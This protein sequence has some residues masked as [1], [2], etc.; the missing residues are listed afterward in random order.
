MSVPIRRLPH[1][2]AVVPIAF[3]RARTGAYAREKGLGR[4]GRC[5]VSPC[6][7]FLPGE[8]RFVRYVGTA[9]IASTVCF[10]CPNF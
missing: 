2:V 10:R 1:T 6:Q 7:R 8:M 4:N 5:R 9:A 3:Q